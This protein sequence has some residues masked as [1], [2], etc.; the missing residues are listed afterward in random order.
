MSYVVGKL[1]WRWNQWFAKLSRVIDHY[2]ATHPEAGR[3][4]NAPADRETPQE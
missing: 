4:P 1:T 3:E 2:D